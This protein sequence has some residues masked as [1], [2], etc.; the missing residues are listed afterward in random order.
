S[1]ISPLDPGR[2]PAYRAAGTYDAIF[3]QVLPNADIHFVVQ[4]FGTYHPL[5]V[6]RA[7]RTEN[8]RHHYGDGGLDDVAKSE[9]LEVFAPRDE[10]WRASVL[11][12]GRAVIR[13]ALRL[14]AR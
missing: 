14:A 8:C 2:S 6:F 7:L 13:D 3:R 11:D 4:E 9:L 1:R 10:R 12:R 5:R